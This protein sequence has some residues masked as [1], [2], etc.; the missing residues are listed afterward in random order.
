MRKPLSFLLASAVWYLAGMEQAAG[1]SG[2]YNPTHPMLEAGP[3][4]VEVRIGAVVA[5]NSGRG[6]DPR[7]VALRQQF[8]NLFPYTSYQLVKEERK[9][10][11]WGSK[12]SFDVPGGRYVL[13]IPREYRSGRIAM[14]ILVIEGA[15]PIVDTS[16]ALRNHGTLLVGGPRQANGVLILSIGADTVD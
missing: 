13:V 1:Q 10:V 12:A 2:A 5:S 6:F 4:V 3:A 7:L 15:R 16:V 11:A 14:K 9:R 8:H